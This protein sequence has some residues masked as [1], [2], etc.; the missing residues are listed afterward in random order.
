MESYQKRMCAC[1]GDLLRGRSDKL[2]CDD[3][4]RNKH[5]NEKRKKS[6]LG[7]RA[8]SIQR[9]LVKNH[10]ILNDML[11]G[12]RRLTISRDHLLRRG[13]CFEIYS[14]QRVFC[15]RKWCFCLD[16]GY[17]QSAGGMIEVDG[18]GKDVGI[19]M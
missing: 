4:C 16:I 1:C 10:R 17:R 13:F 9:Q 18:T 11:A 7:D 2:F 14:H 15:R 6:L 8:R 19:F 3:R 5:H 12:R